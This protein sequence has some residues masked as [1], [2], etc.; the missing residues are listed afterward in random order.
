MLFSFALAAILLKNRSR[1]TIA[2]VAISSL[3]PDVDMLWQHRSEVHA[4]LILLAFA[5]PLAIQYRAFFKPALL[6]L[7]SHSALD[8]FLFDNS[9]QTI[10][11]LANQ[12]VANESIA[13]NIQDSVMRYT[14]ADGIVLL[15]P[16]SG[17]KFS[18]ILGEESYAIIAGFILVMAAFVFLW[19]HFRE[20]FRGGS[21]NS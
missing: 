15:Y 3:L 1:K 6:G 17:E 16:F 11:N 12:V 13:Q 2:L 5:L 9:K 20:P 14:S 10:K 8:I 21:N 7:W 18:I 4:P 19:L